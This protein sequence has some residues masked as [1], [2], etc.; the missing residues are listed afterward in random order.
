MSLPRKFAVGCRQ[1]WREVPGAMRAAMAVLSLVLLTSVFVFRVA[2][3]LPL[4]D[5]LYFAVTTITTVGY[6]DYNLKDAGP[7]LK[8]FGVLLMFCG[9]ALLAVIFSIATDLILRTRF[10]D[11]MAPSAEQS[12]DH[13]IVAGLG[14]IGYRLVCDLVQAGQ[15]V[16]AIEQRADAPFVE[17]ARELAP[18]VLG[19]AKTAETLRKAGAAGA[20]AVV[21]VTDNDLTNLIAALAAKRIQ[22]GC[23]IVLRVFNSELAEKVQRGLALES[24]LSVAAAAAPTFVAAALYPQTLHGFVLDDW[25]LT[26]FHRVAGTAD[27]DSPPAAA[28]QNQAVLLVRPAG[29]NRYEAAAAGRAPRPGDEILGVRW[30]RLAEKRGER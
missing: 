8:L 27:D 7:A 30:F 15:A 26:V 29:A 11:L 20:K 13:V 4:V 19:N 2:M 23:R 22:P 21:A 24:V 25:L 3:G 10:R 5:A 9:A 28:D 12:R 14:N 18:V 1:W 16:V 17:A 6:G